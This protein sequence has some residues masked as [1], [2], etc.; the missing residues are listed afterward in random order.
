MHDARLD[1][2][3][4]LVP[5]TIATLQLAFW[6]VGGLVAGAASTWAATR[7]PLRALRRH[8]HAHWTE[9]A[10]L[11]WPIR[12]GMSVACASTAAAV[13]THAWL[14]SASSFTLEPAVAV[15]TAFVGVYLGAFLVR[16]R[17]SAE[18]RSRPAPLRTDLRHDGLTW[19]LLA[20]HWALVLAILWLVGTE[21]EARD[22]VFLAIGALVHAPVAFLG[23]LPIAKRLGLAMPASARLQRIVEQASRDAGIPFSACWEIDWS[24]ANA[25]AYPWSREL[26]FTQAL[27]RALDDEEIRGVALHELGHVGE[28][29]PTRLTRSAAVLA[30]F[31]LC[32][33]GL[34]LDRFGP[35]ASLGVLALSLGVP[36]VAMRRLQR[37][38]A[39]ADE[40]A[41]R[42]TGD[43][44]RYARALE[45]VYRTNLIPAV[46]SGRKTHPDL[47]DR[48]AGAADGPADPRP[49]PPSRR[50]VEA[51]SGVALVV[52]FVFATG[53]NIAWRALEP[54]WRLDPTA[55]AHRAVALRRGDELFAI[56]SRHASSDPDYAIRLMVALA[57]RTP[58]DHDAAAY[59]ATLLSG[60]GRCDEARSALAAAR[61]RAAS[62]RVERCSWLT[63]AV[64]AVELA[65]SSATRP[66]TRRNAEA[67][68]PESAG[69]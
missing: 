64:E 58:E 54:A 17:V 65:C 41:T 39:R 52:G 66:A 35:M 5:L 3:R 15:P 32:G 48:M 37:F 69:P 4:T 18:T 19:I 53:M 62:E 28:D 47:H 25:F 51:A 7:L 42:V 40:F 44:A 60:Q 6:L 57:E 56:A 34:V 43:P 63:G 68:L 8:P 26:V 13:C 12:K 36:A 46:L 45:T 2:M 10:R 33:V 59:S 23:G 31:P 9:R 14:S 50:A 67:R 27:V 20:P 49:A 24:M 61:A 55:L 16:R 30:I 1:T 21:F 29:L 22:L 38:E 11:V